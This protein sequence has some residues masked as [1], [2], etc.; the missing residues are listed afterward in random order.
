MTEQEWHSC[1]DP[2]LI[3]TINPKFNP[4]RMLDFICDS[5]S[6][7]RTKR[8]Q[9]KL[10]LL[11]CAC[12]RRYWQ[13]LNETSRKAVIAGERYADGLATK[14]E[15]WNIRQT[16]DRYDGPKCREDDIACSAVQSDSAIAAIMAVGISYSLLCRTPV[17]SDDYWTHMCAEAELIREVFGNPFQPIATSSEWATP[18]VIAISRLIYE[19]RC[20]EEMCILA[21]SLEE[22][23]CN[24]TAVLNHCRYP[25]QH[26]RGCWVLDLLLGKV[27]EQKRGES[28]K[29]G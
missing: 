18:A 9:R 17:S 8:G 13:F 1:A 6:L 7:A 29:S 3:R 16:I 26:V 14:K 27:R 2:Q 22:A 25:G 20:F 10:R 12:S 28:R 21:D 11:A 19:D 4:R 24:S 5:S 15:L 23:G